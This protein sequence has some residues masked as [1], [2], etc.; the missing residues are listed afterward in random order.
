[1]RL[2]HIIDWI[3]PFVE[4]PVDSTQNRTWYWSRVVA[5]TAVRAPQQRAGIGEGWIIKA[6]M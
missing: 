5:E 1:M 6:K 3:R 4:D 2:D